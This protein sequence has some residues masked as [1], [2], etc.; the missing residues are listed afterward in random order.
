MGNGIAQ[1]A[2]ASGLTVLMSDINQDFCDRGMANIAKKP[3]PDGIQG[4]NG[5][6]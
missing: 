2:A 6:G 1:V 3:G 5:S 4:Q